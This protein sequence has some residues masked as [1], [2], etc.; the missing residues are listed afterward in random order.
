MTRLSPSHASWFAIGRGMRGVFALTFLVATAASALAQDEGRRG[1]R[2]RG[3]RPGFGGGGPG[4]GGG[5]PGGPGFGGGGFR[6]G[7]GGGDPTIGLLMNEKVR[8]EIGLETAQVEALQKLMQRMREDRPERPDFGSLDEEG[9]REA[10]EQM[11]EQMK[12]QGEKVLAQL[13]EVLYPNQLERLQE[14]ALQL[15][16]S[17][18]LED[19]D[20]VEKLGLTEQQKEQL[21]AKREEFRE[22]ARQRMQEIFAGGGGDREKMGEAFRQMRSEMEENLLS[23]LS[24]EQR[25]TFDEMK[26]EAFEMP[27]PEG[28]GFGGRGG[29]GGDRG[30]DRGGFGRGGDRRGDQRDRPPLE[31]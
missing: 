22:T 26:G 7:P 20:V 16:G 12:E 11:R 29:P 14:I 1:P 17:G 9:R 3:G 24:E 21:S 10:I 23:V 5:G 15:R 13:E 28:R 4:F 2:D 25:K 31:E 18:A 19:P 8:E 30:G 6:G 27:R